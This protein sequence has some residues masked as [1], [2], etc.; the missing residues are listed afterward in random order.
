M[1]CECENVKFSV[2]YR[3]KREGRRE[4]CLKRTY[5][6]VH[7]LVCHYVDTEC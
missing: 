6:S 5:H 4:A 7:C 2:E 3:L 1:V